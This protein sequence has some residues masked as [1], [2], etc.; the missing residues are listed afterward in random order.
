VVLGENPYIEPD[1]VLSDGVGKLISIGLDPAAQF[2]GFSL[3]SGRPG[4][5]KSRLL[6]EAAR[7]RLDSSAD[8]HIP[9][10]VDLADFAGSGLMDLYEYAAVQVTDKFSLSTDWEV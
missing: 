6:Y 2:Q 10:L 3:I 7:L 8:A 9:L 1:L 4:S 5:G